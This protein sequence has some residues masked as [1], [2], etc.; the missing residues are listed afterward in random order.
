M[1]GC[2]RGDLKNGRYGWSQVF[3]TDSFPKNRKTL[4][5]MMFSCRFGISARTG[6][7]FNE[8]KETSGRRTLFL[9]SLHKRF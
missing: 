1:F 8:E 7:L 5:K 2:D 9:E 6:K 3:S 4:Q